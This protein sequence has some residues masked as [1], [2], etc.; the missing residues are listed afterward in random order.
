[1]IDD[2]RIRCW[3]VGDDVVRV[4]HDQERGRPVRDEARLLQKI[5]LERFQSGLSWEKLRYCGN[6]GR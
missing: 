4:Y 5:W 6:L 2:G 3:P 1:V